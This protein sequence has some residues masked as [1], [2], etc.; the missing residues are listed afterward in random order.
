MQNPT[1][2]DPNFNALVF[3]SL[4]LILLNAQDEVSKII[5]MLEPYMTLII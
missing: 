2:V 3:E 5:S 4:A 1:D